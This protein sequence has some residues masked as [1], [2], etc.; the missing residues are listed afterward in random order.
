MYKRQA[1]TRTRQELDELK[2]VLV[3]LSDQNAIVEPD[4][5][6]VSPTLPSSPTVPCPGN[7][8]LELTETDI[9]VPSV[10]LQGCTGTGSEELEVESAS[11]ITKRVRN[12]PRMRHPS[13]LYISPYVN[14]ITKVYKSRKRTRSPVH[15]LNDEG[16]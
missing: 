15:P 6:R 7:M 11:P 1:H 3:G 5:D 16:P 9:P 10:S 13:V 14:P 2:R 12:D 8:L 4:M